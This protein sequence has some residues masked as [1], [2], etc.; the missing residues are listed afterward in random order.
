[1]AEQVGQYGRY[2]FWEILPGFLTWATFFIAIGLTFFAPVA[3]AV[4]IV[5]FDLYWT[6]KVLYFVIHMIAAYRKYRLTTKKDWYQEI[7]KIE[8]WDEIYHVMMFP[9]YQEGLAVL[10]E[11]LNGVKDSVYRNDRFIIVVG[12]EEPE[13]ETFET[14]QE[15]LKKEFGETFYSLMFTI[16]P[17]GIPGELPGK[18][19]NMKWMGEK[20]KER[21]DALHIP[22]EKVIVSAFD[23][24]TIAHKQYFA[25]LTH[26]FLTEENPLRS[27]YQP[28]VLFSNNIWNATAP[29]RIASF[30]TTFW[31]LSE[32]V[33]PE[34]LW[35]FSSHSMPFK[36]LVDVGFHEPDLVS[37]D[38]RIFLQGLL[39]YNGDYRVTPVFLPV[40]MDAV[41]GDTYGESLKALYKQLRRW[42]WGVEHVPYMYGEFKKR[43]QIPF[44]TKFKFFFNE[45]EGKYTQTTAPLLIFVLGYLPFMIHKN[46]TALVTNSPFTLEFMMRIA[47]V[48][49]F[50]TGF[51][52]LLLL[53]SRPKE[54]K[55]W[56]W[57]VMILQWGL[58]PVTFIIF[59]AFPAID[60]QTRFMLGKYLGFNVTKKKR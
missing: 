20:L 44:R 2:R 24:D 6:L 41:E 11:A 51:I 8:G 22:Y 34:R 58:M 47:T 18:G 19:S 52:S 15:E 36:M 42:S 23:V 39:H 43:P 30:G 59:G 55:R 40:Q 13:K 60:A 1:M 57:L 3:A 29:V 35:T 53:P 16:H 10:R 25:K 27:S 45:L 49:V 32:L 37:E 5:I 54:V 56:N 9:T 46:G 33:R 7:Q 38:S 50:V 48:G 28:V 31:L 14:Y 26:L 12:G 4:F 17:R 21:I